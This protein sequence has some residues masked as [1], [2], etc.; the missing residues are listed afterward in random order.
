MIHIESVAAFLALFCGYNVFSTFLQYFYYWRQAA[1][2]S[3]EHGWKCQPTKLATVG[4]TR[5]WIPCLGLKEKSRHPKHRLFA[6]VNIL[7]S[8]L[9]A[10]AVAECA[11]RGWT[12]MVF[13][14]SAYPWWASLGTVCLAH[15]WQNVIE[16]YWHRIMHWPEVY[17]RLHKYHH[18]Y[19]SPEPFDDLFI[20]PLEAFGYLC[21]LWSPPFVFPLSIVG[22]LSY[23]VVNGICGVTDHSG[24]RLSVPG[25]YNTEDH[26][27]H[28]SR[29]S[30][31]F[32]FPLPALDVLHGTYTGSWL[33]RTYSCRPLHQPGEPAP[34]GAASERKGK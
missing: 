22:F 29:V 9:F 27:L 15:V 18:Y 24:I 34:A 14:A 20:H 12:R 8:S 11:M 19:K 23:M 7:Q 17:K 13:D 6:T 1:S 32:G 26:D 5:W 30:V 10:G 2:A 33:G 4:D 3:Q 25:I 31:N 21:I 16:Y 28:H